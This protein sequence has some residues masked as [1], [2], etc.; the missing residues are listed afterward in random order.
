MAG[1][2]ATLLRRLLEAVLVDRL[3]RSPVVVLT[4][5][6]QT[7][8]TTLARSFPGASQRVF[9]TLDALATLDRARREPEALVAGPAPLTI[10]E[11]QRAPDLLLA[12]KQEVDRL[13]QSGRFLLTG[14]ANLLLLGAVSESL[15][16]RAVHL[17]LRP[18]TEREKRR[19]PS[20]PAWSALLAADTPRRALACVHAAGSLDWRR[21][22]LTGG[23][24]PAVLSASEEDRHLWFEGYVETYVHRDLRDLAHVGDLAAFARFMRLCALRNGGLLNQADLARDAAISRTTAQ[25]WLSI[26]EASFLV[27]L[28][29]PFA[30][31]KAKRLIKSPKLYAFDTGLALHLAGV[32]DPEELRTQTNAG[33]WMENLLL[34]DLL[35][36]RETEVRKPTVLYRRTATGEEID[37]V[38]EHGRRL[39][40]IE[41]KT[42][43]SIRTANAKALDA[44]CEE[45][46]PRAPFGLLVFDGTESHQ[47]TRHVVAVPIGALL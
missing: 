32:D 19:D 37:L 39:L 6:R 24:P 21:A 42:A 25:R 46:G 5:A 9:F 31:S 41:V 23:L 35:A 22:A 33:A 16:G 4:G 12:I 43:H 17:V 1:D 40:P 13:R 26:L 34:N 7:G 45:L 29:Q 10:D 2:K 28:L 47:L 30:E 20:P 18:L 3:R 8:K 14:S 36:W 11:V 38:V 15:A 27:T 44:F